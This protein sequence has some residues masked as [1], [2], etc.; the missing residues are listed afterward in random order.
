M[1]RGTYDDTHRKILESAMRMFMEN[2]FERTNL[3]DLCAEAGITTGSLYRHFDSKEDL[4]S[5]LVQ[6]AVDEIRELF[7][8]SETACDQ[9]LREGRV[10]DLWNIV[11]AEKLVET[12]VEQVSTE[13]SD[14]SKWVSTKVLEAV[15][16]KNSV[17]VEI[18]AKPVEPDKYLLVPEDTEFVMDLQ[19]PDIEE[20][21]DA[22][23]NHQILVMRHKSDVAAV[24]YFERKGVSTILRF[25]ATRKKYHGR[26]FGE[27]RVQAY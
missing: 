6:P 20:T 10:L 26:A 21:A 9:A 3:R 12:N 13:K 2:G 8:E 23:K 4:F 18:E 19:I 24:L 27:Q 1:A 22:V 17:M 11:S 7:A 25:W 5:S 16:D 14:I 15:C